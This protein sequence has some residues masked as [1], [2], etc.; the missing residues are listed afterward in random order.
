MD[1]SGISIQQDPSVEPK[2]E[3]LVAVQAQNWIREALPTGWTLEMTQIQQVLKNLNQTQET[4]KS[5]NQTAFRADALLKINDG[6]KNQAKFI[7]EIKRQLA[8]RDITAI[9]KKLTA[10]QSLIENSVP[11][12]M[13]RHISESAQ[14]E[15]KIL[16]I[17][18]ADATGNLQINYPKT[19]TYIRD[20]GEKTDPWRGPGR[21][22]NSLRGAP[23]ARVL[24][25]LIEARPPYSIPQIIKHSKSSSGVTYRVIEYLEREGL[26]ELSQNSE[27]SKPTKQVISCSWRRII[28]L[29][30]SYYEFQS[31]NHVS[32]WIEPR[33]MESLL[34]KLK[35]DK[36]LSYAIT[37][38]L[39]ANT[40]SPL[41][42][43]KLAMLYSDNVELLAK[44]LNL[45]PVKSGAN[46]LL[47]STKYDSIFEN[48]K[49]I[50]GLRY[51]SIVQSALDLLTS[52][53]RGPSE[54]EDLLEWMEDNQYEWRK[55]L[56]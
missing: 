48:T 24:Q 42:N 47:A 33:G 54:G 52:P 39:A 14:R 29:W 32:S 38:S 19:S 1:I 10:I 40:Y 16:G 5:I 22:R 36:K 53:G 23:A 50:K 25:S 49:E 37:G 6:P 28:N 44:K 30:S 34:K 55:E 21:P 15:L 31:S 46:V 41:A 12:V 17:S 56:N 4:I 43:P 2:T 26:L 27:I 45:T 8:S 13:A 3:E 7:V 18:Y 51:V 35:V 20:V 9:Y 11:M